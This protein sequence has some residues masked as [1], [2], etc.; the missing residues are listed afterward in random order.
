MSDP[1]PDAY[2]AGSGSVRAS[3]GPVWPAET[4]ALRHA[5]MLQ[6]CFAGPEMRWSDALIARTRRHA[7]GCL[8]SVEMRMRLELERLSPIPFPTE[9]L[10]WPMVQ[11]QP[12]LISVPL[13]DHFRD[14][15]ALSL[16][17]QDVLYAMPPGSGDAPLPPEIAELLATITLAQAGW[18]DAAPDQ[19]P[20][21]ANLPAELMAELVWT[22]SAMLVDGIVAGG[23]LPAGQAMAIAERA[24][25]AVLA[26]HDEQNMPFATAALFAHRARA[27]GVGEPGLLRLARERHILPLLGLLADRTGIEL[28]TLVRAVLEESEQAIFILCRAADFPREVAVRLVLGRRCV[29]RGVGDSMLVEYADSYE[30]ITSEAARMAV[31]ALRLP[32]AFRVRLSP[33]HGRIDADGG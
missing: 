26:S 29:A 33:A 20:M 3:S 9:A 16:M 2:P 13:L 7:G 32:E 28:L 18:A 23:G 27:S 30:G 11:R 14:R 19:T 6:R 15:A 5:I 17:Q 22:V 8:S 4:D 12:T 31:T 25:A 21:R 1:S 24:G 10:C